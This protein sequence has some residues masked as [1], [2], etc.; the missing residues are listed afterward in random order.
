MITLKSRRE[1]SLMR[2]AGRL[3]AEAHAIVRSMIAPG[4]TTGELDA[5]IERLFDERGAIPLFRGVPGSDGAG[6]FPA[7]T[8]ISINEEVVH[9][10]PGS[11]VLEEGDIVSVDTGCKL[12]GWCGDAAWTYPV[13]EVDD[14]KRRLLEIGEATLATAIRELG[15]CAHWSEVAAQMEKL[16]RQAGFSLVRDFVGHGIGQQMH[17]EPQVPNYPGRSDFKL[18]SG[19]VLAIEPM[20]NAGTSEVVIVEDGWTVETRDGAPS[21][22]FEHTV[23][24]TVDGPVVLTEGVGAPLPA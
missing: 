9:G 14:E 8:C 21:V 10:I 12:N 22:H 7:V 17:E 4:I 6:P 3:V 16:V 15:R 23:A 19:L 5:A 13:G 24:L 1:I 11:R 20:V 18:E 2:E